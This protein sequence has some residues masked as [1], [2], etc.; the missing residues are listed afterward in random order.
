MTMD[1]RGIR[2]QEYYGALIAFVNTVIDYNHEY[3]EFLNEEFLRLDHVPR[4][5]KF[6]LVL[7]FYKWRRE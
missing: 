3:V 1:F 4:I 7:T 6:L 5:I 2:L